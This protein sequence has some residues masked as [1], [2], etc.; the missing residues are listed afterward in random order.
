MEKKGKLGIN[1][2]DALAGPKV[3]QGLDDTRMDVLALTPVCLSCTFIFQ[4]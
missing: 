4:S 1:Q 3:D 2:L